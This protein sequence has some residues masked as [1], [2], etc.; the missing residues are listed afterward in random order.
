MGKK[1][2]MNSST[3][4]NKILELIE[5]EKLFNIPNKKLEI[6]IHPNSLVH[7]IVELKNDLSE[8]I[9]HENSMIIPIANAIFDENLSIDKFY[10][11]KNT[12]FNKI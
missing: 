9:Y 3:L 6:I 11:I 4:M 2:S 5:A 7:A 8:F 1:I 10:K 12:A